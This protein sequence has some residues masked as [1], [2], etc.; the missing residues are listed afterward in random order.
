MKKLKAILIGAGCRGMK[1]T[2]IMADMGDKYQVIAV[3]EPIDAR[4]NYIKEKHKLPDDMCFTTWEPLLELGKIADIAIIATMDRDHLEPSL[5]AISLKYD[6]LLEKPVSAIPEECIRISEAAKKEGVKVVVCHVLRY[7]PIFVKLKELIDDGVIGKMMVINHEECVGNLHFAHSF[8]R[9][10]WGNSD[11]SSPMLLQKSCHDIDILQWLIGKECNK[12]QSFGKLTHF[13]KEN[14]PENAA[15]YCIDNCPNADTCPY[16]AV[17][18]Y[19]EDK[20]GRGACTTLVNPTDEEIKDALRKNQYGKCVYKCNNNVVDHQ[21]VNMLFEDDV[22][23]TFT[24]TGFNKGG[25]FIHIM[26]TKGEIHAALD[27]KTPIEIYDFSTK[28]ITTIPMIAKDGIANSH[29][30]GD[31]GIIATLYDYLTGQYSGKSISDVGISCDNHL[32]V[33]AAEHSRKTNTVVDVRQ[34]KEALKSGI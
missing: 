8:V 28:E 27:G 32:I 22:A 23:V 12:V 30:G 15:D 26:G 17:K 4:R 1:Y 31:E 3:A 5:K 18:F 7:A 2:D 13:K 29:G 25:R 9:G 19:I 20:G 14:A 16:N 10:R 11:T 33:F 6:L 24:M 34:F 21:V